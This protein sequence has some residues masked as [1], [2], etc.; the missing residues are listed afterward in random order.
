MVKPVTN[1][2]LAELLVEGG[3]GN[4]HAVFARQVNHEASRNGGLITK[5]DAASVYR[6]LRGGCPTPP[7]TESIAAVLSRRLGR[8]VDTYELGFPDP[9]PPRGILD[10]SFPESVPDAIGA[11]TELWRYLESRRE[12]TPATT[13]TPAAASDA[14][15]RWHFDPADAD[16]SHVGA[17]AVT[18]T[19]IDELRSMHR[20][21]ILIDQAHGGGHVRPFLTGYLRREVAPLLQGRYGDQVGRPLFGAAAALAGMV[22][23]ASHDIGDERVAQQSFIQALRLAKAAGDRALGASTLAQLADQALFLSHPADAVRLANAAVTGA[24]GAP[25]A[26]LTTLHMRQAEAYAAAGDNHASTTALRDA[27]RTM[28][29]ASDDDTPEWLDRAT[30]AH[31][32]ATRVRCLFA[33]GQP[34]QALT[35][36]DAALALPL[37]H[38]RTRAVHCALVASVH[39]DLGN[40]AQACAVGHQAVSLAA[41]VRSRRCAA[42]VHELI[43]RLTGHHGEPAV[44][45][46][47]NHARTAPA[48]E[49][50]WAPDIP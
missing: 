4:D 16:V 50:A 41:N 38:I 11:A 32:A 22:G 40:I 42:C 27:Q 49:R 10:L 43:R 23:S 9:S 31:L 2:D 47:I 44:D 39:A 29:A 30:P 24:Y 28:D 37:R 48:Y 8:R 34:D 6:W 21:F 20:D 12:P 7:A 33:L 15:W 13:F 17:R 25:A 35:V 3:Y 26:V 1:H 5:Y 36:A 14:G 19:H 46:L 45:E 18:S